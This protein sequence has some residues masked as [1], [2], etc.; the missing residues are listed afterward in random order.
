VEKEKVSIKK[1][2][3]KLKIKY[4]TAK[5][6]LKNYRKKGHIFQRKKEL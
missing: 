2:A 1:A 4:E 5:I 6:I 3:S